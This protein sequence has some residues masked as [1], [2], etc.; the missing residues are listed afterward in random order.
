MLPAETSFNPCLISWLLSCWLSW[1]EL[2][3][4]CCYISWLLSVRFFDEQGAVPSSIEN[5][6]EQCFQE[7]KLNR[8]SH[9]YLGVL[10]TKSKQDSNIAAY[11]QHNSTE[12]I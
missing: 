6:A 9:R 3:D 7:E 11:S 4:V 10:A 5:K 12:T 8:Y 1:F 2:R